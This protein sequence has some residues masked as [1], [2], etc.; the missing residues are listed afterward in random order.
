MI[1]QLHQPE[2]KQA[3]ARAV[4]EALPEWFGI[5]EAREDYIRR[6]ASQPCFAA[7]EGS[8]PVGFLCLEETGS[9]TVEM[10]VMG[11]VK[12]CHRRGLGTAL[13]RAARAWAAEQGYAFM[14]VKTVQE[15]RYPEYDATNA[16]YRRLGFQ[17]FEVF[18]TLWD[19]WNPCQVYVMA[20]R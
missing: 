19:E 1:R 10:Y 15:G 18:P 5:P 17:E 12:R 20:I 7:Y 4:L 9:A 6:S 16:F 3:V 8:E 13:F 14:Q 2:E 11:V